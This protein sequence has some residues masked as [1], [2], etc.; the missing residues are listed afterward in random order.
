MLGMGW[1]PFTLANGAAP[2]I[3]A[4]V[5]IGATLLIEEHV[6]ALLAFL[7]AAEPWLFLAAILALLELVRRLRRRRREP[8]PETRS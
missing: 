6:A 2:L 4:D 3:W 7:R 5:W 1:V 8:A